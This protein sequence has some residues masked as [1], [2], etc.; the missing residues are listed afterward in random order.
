MSTGHGTYENKNKNLEQK[1][2]HDSH[3]LILTEN[4]VL[5]Q[6]GTTHLVAQR[7]AI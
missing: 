7:Q 1:V 6:N 5:R 3:I 4:S 2:A